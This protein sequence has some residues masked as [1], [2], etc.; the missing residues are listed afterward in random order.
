[1]KY[2]I[3][4]GQDTGFYG[5][6]AKERPDMVIEVHA[7]N[8]KEAVHICLDKLLESPKKY[9]RAFMFDNKDNMIIHIE[10]CY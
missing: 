6:F 1:M 8:K 4:L 2:E 3:H 9:E 7:R 10:R 5:V